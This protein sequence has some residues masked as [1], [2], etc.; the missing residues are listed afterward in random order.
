MEFDFNQQ[1][2]II[3]SIEEGQQILNEVWAFV[4]KSQA[5]NQAEKQAAQEKIAHLE[6]KLKTNSSNSSKPPSTDPF[7]KTKSRKKFHGPGKNKRLKQ[8]AQPGHKGNGRKLVPSTEVKSTI[9]CLPNTSCE[10]GGHVDADLKKVKRVQQFELPEVKPIITEYQQVYGTCTACGTTHCG[11]LPE[12][13]SNQLLGPRALSAVGICSGVFRLSKRLTKDLMQNFFNLEISLGTVSNAEEIVS[14][15]LKEPVQELVE[16]VQ[17]SPIVNADETSHKQQGKKMWMW[18]ATTLLAAVFLIRTSRCMESAKALLGENFFGILI[19]DRYSAYNWIATKFRQFCWAHLSR[20][21]I[22]ISERSG[23]SGEIG[24]EIGSYIR[25]MF[26]LWHKLK[27]GKISRTTFQIRMKPIRRHTER[28][29][30]EGTQ[31][32]HTKTENTCKKILKQKDALWTFVDIEGVEPTNNHAEQ[33]IR[34]YVIWRKLSFG[35]QSERGNLFVERM[36]SVTTTC[37][38]QERNQYHYI[39]AAVDAYLKKQP[40]PSLLPEKTDVEPEKLAA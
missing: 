29:L 17:K 18:V 25:L 26:H 1:P 12:G 2:P 28:L 30:K 23:R 33:Q 35:T 7:R 16:H 5:D 13:V 10:C 15:A 38:L 32:G 39:T 40:Y 9:V 6:E 14:A 31:C 19:S 36:M 34:Y 4:N 21:M 22:K 3:H 11:T 20:D 27:D 24:D 37:R 8:G